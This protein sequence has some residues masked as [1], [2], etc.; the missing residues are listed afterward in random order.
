MTVF[1]KK[2]VLHVRRSKLLGTAGFQTEA[3]VKKGE[4]SE[5][6]RGLWYRMKHVT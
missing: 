4:I 5:K 3:S 6:L 1:V 2:S